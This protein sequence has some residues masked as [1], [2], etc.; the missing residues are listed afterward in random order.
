V[1]SVISSLIIIA[2]GAIG[3]TLFARGLRSDR[4]VRQ[5]L[6]SVLRSRRRQVTPD[7][8]AQLLPWARTTLVIG[9]V[10]SVIITVMGAIALVIA[11]ATTFG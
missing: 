9:L 6:E 5:T 8:V 3:A 11:V 7:A 4:Y 10:M 1:N 2:V